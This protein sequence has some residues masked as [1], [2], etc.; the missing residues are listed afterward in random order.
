M[1][2][3]SV[4]SSAP[5]AAAD[6]LASVLPVL[7]F[8]SAVQALSH[9]D[10]EHDQCLLGGGVGSGKTYLH[11]PHAALRMAAPRS[12]TDLRP[13]QVDQLHGLFTN[14]QK[15]LDQAV[16]PSIQAFH[17]RLGMEKPVYD[18]KPPLSWIRNWIRLKI[19]VPSPAKYRNV[20]TAPTGYHA[21]CGT[22]HNE[23]AAAQYQTIDLSSVRIEEAIYCS[24]T[25]IDTILERVRCTRGD[26]DFCRR[27]HRHQKWLIFNP[28]R[29]AHPWLIVWLD[30]LE[31]AAKNY[32]H[33]LR[34]D[35]TCDGCEYVTES[36]KRFPRSHG[37]VLQH[38]SW[39]LL[40]QGIGPTALYRSRTSDN[41][42]NLNDGYGERLAANMS[43]NTA[44]RRLGGEILRETAGGAYTDFSDENVRP[45][46]YDPDRT[47]YVGL[48]FNLS[49]RAAVFAQPLIHGEYDSQ[50]SRPGVQHVGVFGEF[51]NAG[52]MD[53]RRFANALVRG[54]RGDGGDEQPKY[55]S[56]QWRG[57]PPPCDA[58]CA[59][60]CQEGH[61]NGLKAHRGMIQVFG[62]QRASARSS[63]SG[64]SSW[65]IVDRVFRK[66]EN[67]SLEVP[68]DQPPP[69]LRVDSVNAKFCSSLDVRSLWIDPR[70]EELIRDFEQV[71][72]DDDGQSLREWRRGAMGTEKHRTHLS[73]GLG[74]MIHRLYPG[75]DDGQGLASLETFLEQAEDAAAHRAPRTRLPRVR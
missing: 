25:S 24:M 16:I 63:Q 33:A 46:K 54:D 38:R 72:W 41:A 65:D 18:V 2:G 14:T 51:F 39:P 48:D 4:A 34:E 57:L 61:W 45:V 12:A 11:G 56:E 10:D 36:G 44:R 37:P 21:L 59:Q 43:K 15:Q 8:N 13:R 70:C 50:Y 49:P 60:P 26:R 42:E 68:D 55:A 58:E 6:L 23:R 32:Y 75:G 62:D 29:G 47:L 3:A 19:D 53:D 40:Q 31:A 30:A 52:E 66:L 74:Y 28:P 20:L 73:D 64:E 17:V 27:Y 1:N 35:E 67:Y 69:R 71:M 22:L 7:R 9:F 5:P